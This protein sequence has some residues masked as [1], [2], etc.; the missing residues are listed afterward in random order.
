M[1][2][3]YV[4][5]GALLAVVALAAWVS[6]PATAIATL[7]WLAA[8]PL[9]FGLALVTL[10]VVRPFLAWPTTLVA[11]AVGFGYGWPGVP[12]GVLLLTL[13]ALPPYYLARVGRA[14]P[15]AAGNEPT[16]SERV[17]TAGERLVGVAGGTRTVVAARLLPAPSDAIS[18]GAGVAG[19]RLRPFLAGTAIGESPWVLAGVAIGVSADRLVA[20]DLSVLDPTLFVGMAGIALLLLAGPFY[21]AYR[22]RRGRSVTG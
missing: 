18:L 4:G 9:R 8:D 10:A 11:V 5:G 21:R 22:R 19:V 13:T 14:P 12:F 17:A 1:N 6:S 16:A 20:G 15:G 7:E 2:R 3:R